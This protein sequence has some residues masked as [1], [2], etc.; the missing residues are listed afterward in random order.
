MARIAE[1]EKMENIKRATMEALVEHGYGRMSI[2]LSVKKQEYHQA[3][4][5]GITIIRRN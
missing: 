4:Y 5:T 1:P 2:A 3:I